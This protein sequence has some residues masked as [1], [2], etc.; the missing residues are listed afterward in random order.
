M[1]FLSLELKGYL[2]LSHCGTHHLTAGF[3]DICT[4]FLGNNGTGK[5]SILRTLTP[6]PETRT[7]Y[8]KNGYCKKVIEHEGHTYELISDF[9][10]ATKAHSFIKDGIEQ[11]I[12]GATE[13]QTELCNEAFGFSQMIETLTSGGYD[14]CNM[15]R[16]ERKELLMSTYP[17]DLSFILEYHRK[18]RSQ[19]NMHN[20][21]LKMLRER[22]HT[23]K[24]KLLDN[25]QLQ[26]L[27]KFQKD[28][29]VLANDIDRFI[30][31][32]EQDKK[33]F[34][35]DPQY[36]EALRKFRN[37]ELIDVDDLVRQCYDVRNRAW[38][39]R[40]EHPDIFTDADFFTEYR[41]KA[42][43]TTRLEQD[44]AENEQSIHKTREELEEYEK[45]KDLNIEQELATLTNRQEWLHN[46]INKLH[47][48]ESCPKWSRETLERAEVEFPVLRDLCIEI[49][50][51]NC[52]VWSREKLHEAQTDIQVKTRQIQNIRQNLVAA[53]TNLRNLKA[54]QQNENNYTIPRGC[55]MTCQLK[56]SV[57][58]MQ[59]RTQSELDKWSSEVSDL[60]DAITSLESSLEESK[61]AIQMPSLAMPKIEMIQGIIQGYNGG[62]T[63]LNDLDV[64][65]VLNEDPFSISNNFLKLINGNKVM[66]TR[67]EYEK[68]LMMTQTKISALKTAQSA[69]KELQLISKTIYEKQT[70]LS[71]L[72][73]Q[74]DGQVKHLEVMKT[75]CQKLKEMSELVERITMLT[76]NYQEF[77]KASWV[78]ARIDFDNEIIREYTAIK[79]VVYEKLREIDTTIQEQENWLT[80]LND[81]IMPN[82][83]SIEAEVK[84]WIAIESGLSPNSGIPHVYMVR[85]INR[86]ITRVNEFIKAVW[87]YDMELVYLDEDKPL[88]YGIQVMIN[89]NSIVKDLSILSSGQ[90]AMVSLAFTLAIC[91]DRGYA[92]KYPMKMDEVDP[93]LTENH[94]IRLTNL[95][96][97][98]IQ[99]KQITQLFLVNHFV[100]HTGMTDCGVIC[101]STEGIVVPAEY[102]KHVTIK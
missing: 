89:K 24:G 60:T 36:S 4:A 33:R 34:E 88:D 27:Y 70:A 21:N 22:E 49:H 74:Y 11:N 90:K 29:N 57:L 31:L 19:I 77:S 87:Y 25:D 81:E 80:R 39:C 101:L 91:M 64:I 7:D 85:Y 32:M 9:K 59:Q 17:S 55:V 100:I 38:A 30:L 102:N 75:K 26:D 83:R 92:T 84:D 8:S 67:Q 45:Y 44:I 58:K 50:G 66:I 71:L 23:L 97:D 54:R 6:Y 35:S 46:E 79:Q 47:V 5:S 43:E 98:W 51:M 72:I 63:V 69:A 99:N 18:V 1:R 3:E 62:K 13:T 86:L 48:D 73:Q 78:I 12:S 52:T 76:K 16:A 93:A 65:D 82:I 41:V 14:M 15:K 68:E 56:N 42:Q 61:Q 96:S 94:R 37:G 53:E 2:P 20:N 40:R 28:L 95:I 10:N